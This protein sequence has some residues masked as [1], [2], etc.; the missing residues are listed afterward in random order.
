MTKDLKEKA[1]PIKGKDYVQVKDRV[2]YFNQTYPNGCIQTKLLSEPNAEMVV[3]QAIAIPD[4][5]KPNRIFTGHSQAKWNDGYINKTSAMENAET[6]AIGRALASMGIG[7]LDSIASSDEIR[8]AENDTRADYSKT[9]QDDL[10][11]RFC[12]VHL[13]KYG[14]PSFWGRQYPTCM[15][16]NGTEPCKTRQEVIVESSDEL[17]DSVDIP[18]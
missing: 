16:A 8:K 3:I 14:K 18:F 15:N 5:D 7:V 4:M 2:I 10:S 11:A 17:A 1:I 13:S 9:I 12:V 6:S